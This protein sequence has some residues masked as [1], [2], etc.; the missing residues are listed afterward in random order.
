MPK[1]KEETS[2]LSYLFSIFATFY[3]QLNIRNKEI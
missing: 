1:K 3:T 2:R